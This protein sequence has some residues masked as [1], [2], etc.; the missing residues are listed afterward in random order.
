M[1]LF[2]DLKR[3]N[4]L[5]KKK[6]MAV[7]EEV[8]DSGWFCLGEPVEKFEE[9]FAKFCGKKYC[10]GVNSGTDALMLS[11]LAYGIGKDDEVIVPVHTYFS[12]AMVVSNIGA[13]PVF[14]DIEPES[15]N[16]AP[17]LIE[18]KIS[19]K[20]KAIIPVHLYGQPSEMEPIVKIAKKH[21][22]A[23]IEDCCQ[24]HGAKYK[25]KILPH[26]E[27]GAFSF[28][29][30][31]NLGCFGDGGAVVTDNPKIKKR[32][33]YLRNDGSVEKYKH[34]VFGYKSRLDTL[35][36]A[37]LSFKLKHLPEF[38]QKRR[39]LAKLYTQLLAKIPQIKTP[40]EMS[41]AYH[42]YHLYVIRTKKRDKLQ[43][44][45]SKQGI[46]TL[47]H[48]PVPVHLQKPYRQQGYKKGDFPTAEKIA[49]E[50]ISLPL[51]PELEEK[52]VRFVCQKIADFF[53]NL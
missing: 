22:L 11:L 28:Y 38:N 7:I 33:E 16:I 44:Y 53:S 50:V 18:A 35:Q 1:I 41:Y 27:T 6:L 25:G 15:F 52:E 20:T 2:S 47:I 24:A 5:F 23:I 26:T 17:D 51:F 34:E 12:T 30:I 3:Q 46:G 32:L 19:K 29:P 39:R 45:L 9:E 48:Y 4:K 14:V 40:K 43:E 36:A 37:I 31:K 13:K 49:K 21:K 10:V 8:V 42:V